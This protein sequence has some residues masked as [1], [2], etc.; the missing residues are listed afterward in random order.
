MP[1]TQVK[2]VRDLA[3]SV[4]LVA[5]DYD[6]PDRVPHQRLAFRGFEAVRAVGM[7]TGLRQRRVP[8]LAPSPAE[9]STKQTPNRAIGLWVG[10]RPSTKT[11][12]GL[13]RSRR[14]QCVNDYSGSPDIA[15]D[16]RALRVITIISDTH[17]QFYCLVDE[18]EGLCSAYR[19][20]RDEVFFF[21]EY[22][23]DDDRDK[24]GRRRLWSRKAQQ[25][26]RA[27]GTV[28]TI[29]SEQAVEGRDADGAEDQ[30]DETEDAD[31]VGNEQQ[32]VIHAS[33]N[34]GGLS[35][36]AYTQPTTAPPVEYTILYKLASGIEVLSGE[37]CEA[38]IQQ[39]YVS[40]SLKC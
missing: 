2:S 3:F 10:M 7:I 17:V 6:Y 8:P 26:L 29:D 11:D 28:V 1:S 40:L 20:T 13:T 24:D 5:Y 27:L 21:Q 14:G 18:E 37:E 15:C 23:I 34:D 39:F 33:G 12:Y 38:A 9:L 30:A 36:V 32:R 25:T 4:A 35:L 22:R 31:E 19:I 16:A